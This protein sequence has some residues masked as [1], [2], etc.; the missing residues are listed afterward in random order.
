MT[1]NESTQVMDSA[2]ESTAFRSNGLS[3]KSKRMPGKRHK[4]RQFYSI[5]LVHE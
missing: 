3:E 5:K 1:K 2:Y 4:T